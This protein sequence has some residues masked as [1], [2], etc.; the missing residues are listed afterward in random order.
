M[1]D[2]SQGTIFDIDKMKALAQLVAGYLPKRITTT[3]GFTPVYEDGLDAKTD[4]YS[5]DPEQVEGALAL[6]DYANRRRIEAALDEVDRRADW[7]FN[8]AKN[9]VMMFS[10]GPEEYS[11][12]V[13]S[14]TLSSEITNGSVK[15]GPILNAMLKFIDEHLCEGYGVYAMNGSLL[16][17]HVRYSVFYDED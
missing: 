8:S 2:L 14:V 7:D 12:G 6:L 9:P 10:V 1:S 17:S 5:Y 11:V 13:I 15:E 3:V 4:F 16:N